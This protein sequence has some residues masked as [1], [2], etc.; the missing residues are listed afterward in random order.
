MVFPVVMY[1]YESWTIKKAEHQR[2]Y[3]F[4]LWC[5]RRLLRIPWIARMKPVNPKGNQSWIFSGRM[6]AKAEAPAPILW[7]HDAK[8]QP[9][10]KDPDA[11]KEW[12][13]RTGCDRGWDGWMVSPFQWTWVWV[14]SGSWWRTGKTAVLQSME[15]QR[16]IHDWLT[17]LN[18]AVWHPHHLLPCPLVGTLYF[19]WLVLSKP[20]CQFII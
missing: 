2:T 20:L 1:G 18:W 14:S 7:P 5:W 10:R 19:V 6:D 11:G 17:Q 9:I 12:G 4:E 8:S 3:A 15:L 16:V 13:R